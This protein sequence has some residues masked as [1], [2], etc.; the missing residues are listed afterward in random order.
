MY[1][2]RTV[3]TAVWGVLLLLVVLAGV[4]LLV[5]RERARAERRA[6]NLRALFEV[7]RQATANLDRQQVLEVVVQAAQDVMG[8][9]MASILL[10]DGSAQEL[11]AAAIS[12]HLRDR[13]PLGDRVPLGRGLVGAAGQTGRTQLANDISRAPNYVRAPGDW[14]PGSEISVP[15]KSPEALLGVLDVEDERKGVFG[16]DD[17]QVLEALA[18]QLVVSLSKARL[19]ESERRRA[20]RIAS[21]NS[22]GRQITASLSVDG[23]M[24]AAVNAI[25]RDLHYPTRSVMLA[26]PPQPHVPVTRPVRRYYRQS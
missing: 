2:G 9:H 11:V 16:P 20:D 6:R 1:N 17:V 18:E 22:I 12:S 25:D 15:L 24:R 5:R 13:I 23:L 7:S 21:L 8:Y 4:A 14:D 10:L 3:D 19:L 26:A